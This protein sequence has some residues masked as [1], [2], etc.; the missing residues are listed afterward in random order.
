MGMVSTKH[1]TDAGGG[2]LERLVTGQTVFVQGVQNAAVD[3][4]QTVSHIGQGTADDN[5]H[6]IVD[7]AGLH[8]L[9]QFRLGYHL[10]WEKYIFG[11]IV[12]FMCHKFSFNGS[13]FNSELSA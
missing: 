6:G 9:H 11:L 2:L 5:G 4:L 7:V 10:I 12:S 3:R 8:L 13:Q 1:V